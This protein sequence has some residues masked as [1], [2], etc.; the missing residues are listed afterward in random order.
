MRLFFQELR[1]CLGRKAVLVSL[2]VLTLLNLFLSCDITPDPAR[3]LYQALETLPPGRELAYLEKQT[4][5][6]NGF[7]WQ[8]DLGREAERRI[9][10]YTGD[11]YSEAALFDRVREDF[12][13][14]QDYGEYLAQVEENA[15]RLG[16]TAIFS[17]PGGYESK[18]IEKIREAYR[19]LR[20]L[21]PK[22]GCW[23]AL[24]RALTGEFTGLFLLV[25]GC[26]FGVGTIC[27]DL[28]SGSLLLIRSTP[29]GRR[30]LSVCRMGAA[31]VHSLLC[32][33]ALAVLPGVVC[34][35]GGGVDLAAPVQSLPG[36]YTGTIPVTAGG[37]LLC[38]GAFALTAVFVTELLVMAAAQVLVYAATTYQFSVLLVGTEV[39]LRYLVPGSSF[40]NFF[41]YANLLYLADPKE[42]FSGFHC[43]NCFGEPIPL[44]Q[45]LVVFGG[46]MLGLG[47][48]AIYF[49][50]APGRGL[51]LR[52]PKALRKRWGYCQSLFRHEGYKL[53]AVNRCWVWL[54]ALAVWAGWSWVSFDAN[55]DV[56]DL[57]YRSHIQAVEGR[58]DEAAW[59]Y[60]A[61]QEAYFAGLEARLSELAAQL[62]SGAL[63]Q[64]EYDL[65]CVPLRQELL[66]RTAFERFRNSL[67]YLSRQGRKTILYR[68]GYD[69]LVGRTAR[70]A[71]QPR[72]M[73]GLLFL[74]ALISPIYAG[75]N[76]SGMTALIRSTKGG[77]LRL[78]GTKAGL[79]LLLAVVVSLGI[80]GPFTLRTLDAFGTWQIG[81]SSNLLLIAAPDI[82]IWGYLLLTAG[83]RAGGYFLAGATAAGISYFSPNARLALILS[84]LALVVP[85][86]LVWLT[87]PASF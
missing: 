76:G 35:L 31:L 32:G 24:E 82:P 6:L 70:R 4:E 39:V 45:V 60:A 38:R 46:V 34:L 80:S 64:K 5:Y 17:Q 57:L 25:A 85:V 11:F 19:P 33:L 44:A 59:D 37:Y 26:V 54:L 13:R 87:P 50:R 69:R 72:H 48:P 52:L 62:E 51:R 73:L 67:N 2:A 63:E 84:A 53:L 10:L 81:E 42:A 77:R 43:V 40:L 15:E 16:G 36:F 79:V 14:A 28:E 66:S 1:R 68:T 12:A 74:A 7:L 3:Q 9:C 22:P 29:L 71:A 75:D 23:A 65:A 47:L 49:G 55:Y 30:R 27:E 8:E 41:R 61:E 78:M 58:V 56:N 20:E 21:A 86:G 18:V 83:A